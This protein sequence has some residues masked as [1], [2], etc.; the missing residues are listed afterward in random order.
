MKGMPS[1]RAFGTTLVLGAAA[2]A[3]TGS[4]RTEDQAPALDQRLTDIA[5]FVGQWRGTAEGEPGTG[6]VS[7]SYTPILAGK[8]IE[9]HNESRYGSGEIH[10]HRAFWS[11]DRTRSRFVLRQFHQES[12]V[13]QFAAATAGFVEGRLVMDSEAIE[14]IPA[15]FRARETYIFN[16]ADA[17][18]EIFEIAEPGADFQ[19]YSHNRFMRA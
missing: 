16:G 15:G 11:Y 4:G 6:T 10:H 13:N 9:E 3:S 7:R 8:F 17:F 5:R 18:E 14:N 12:F 1:R 19:R 2:C